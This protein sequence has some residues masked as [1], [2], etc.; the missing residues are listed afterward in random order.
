MVYY[1]SLGDN[2][3]DEELAANAQ[4]ML[5]GKGGNLSDRQ[6]RFAQDILS[7]YQ[8]LMQ[9]DLWDKQYNGHPAAKPPQ[10]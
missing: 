10:Q 2:M 4:M 3:R 1:K 5:Q 7:T 9:M 8:L 6:A